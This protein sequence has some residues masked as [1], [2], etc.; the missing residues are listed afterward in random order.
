VSLGIPGLPSAGALLAGAGR[1]L[2]LSTAVAAMVF[3]VCRILRDRWPVFQQ[4]LWGLVL[5][6]LLLPPGLSHPLALGSLWRFLGMD[7]LT[8][9]DGADPLTAIGHADH[10]S[11]PA[12][13]AT[14][15]SEPWALLVLGLWAAASLALLA[16]DLRAHGRYRRL[17][18]QAVPIATPQVVRR[19][20]Q[21]RLRLG[22]RRQVDLRVTEAQVGPF[23]LGVLRP[24]VVVP[25]VLLEPSRAEALGSSL[26]HELAHVAHL[27]FAWLWLERVV[28]R[29]Y[30]FHPVVWLAGRRLRQGREGLCDARVLSSGLMAPRGYARGLIDV[31][32]L[33]LRPAAALSVM[34]NERSLFMRIR[35]T[36]CSAPLP[37]LR[38]APSLAAATL[39]GAFVLPL[40]GMASP[41]DPTPEPAQKPIVWVDPVPG[42]RIT[43]GYGPAVGPFDRKPFVHQGIDLA[44]TAGMPI[45][46]AAAGVVELA[47]ETYPPQPAAGTVVILDHGGGMKSFYAHLGDL[48]VETGDRVASGDTIAR[49]GTTGRTTG[50]HL[51]FEV[52]KDGA[53]VDPG[54]V[55]TD[56]VE[57]R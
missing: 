41:A 7:L 38:S 40:A 1:E 27:D 39:L 37:H 11:L 22:I 3:L 6:R 42:A 55:V 18:R 21:W 2:W 34:A 23:T 8:V 45:R 32:G 47:T 26:A 50:P 46:A 54:K 31:L 43:L 15:W 56:R 33:R 28:E 19:L 53:P 17:A 25:K 52:W 14:G 20:H 13:E 51:H 9:G 30:F 16:R 36:L 10:T 4:A 5:L 57:N 35:R 24:Q 49:I 29:V 44:T 12:G 48:D